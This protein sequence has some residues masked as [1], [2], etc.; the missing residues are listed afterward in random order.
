[1]HEMCS[2]TTDHI[3]TEAVNVMTG[4]RSQ[5]LDILKRASTKYKI[6]SKD[7]DDKR[8]AE[9]RPRPSLPGPHKSVS[10]SISVNELQMTVRTRPQTSGLGLRRVRD[11]LHDLRIANQKH[12]HHQYKRM[13]NSPKTLRV[14]KPLHRR[15][16][17]A[18][19]VMFE[20]DG[21]KQE[22]R[23]PYKSYQDLHILSMYEEEE[24]HDRQ[25]SAAPR[26]A[27]PPPS[28]LRNMSLPHSAPHHAVSSPSLYSSSSGSSSPRPQTPLDDVRVPAYD[29]EDTDCSDNEYLRGRYARCV[30]VV[31]QH[32]TRDAVSHDDNEIVSWSFAPLHRVH[33]HLA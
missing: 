30:Q 7:M 18:S 32:R 10:K 8:A 2:V 4:A 16:S 28:Q 5:L 26:S 33:T 9:L 25:A 15:Q 19:L 27:L 1:M 3:Q 23:V 24:G 12:A 17:Y 14:S 13:A 6:A 29:W 31:Q 20:Y 22:K 11:S 21:A